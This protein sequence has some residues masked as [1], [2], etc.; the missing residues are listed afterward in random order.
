M[1]HTDAKRGLRVATP[2]L[3]IGK[4]R[5]VKWP[6]P[7]KPPQHQLGD[8]DDHEDDE[9][10]GDGEVQLGMYDL[11]PNNR[12]WR[13]IFREHPGCTSRGYLKTLAEVFSPG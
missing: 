10:N 6:Q 2:P 1:R 9:E 5:L 8:V 7:R 4:L 13:G 11:T 12:P 3:P